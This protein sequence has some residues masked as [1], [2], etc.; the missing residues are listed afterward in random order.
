MFLRHS[1][2]R[3]RA[4]LGYTSDAMTRLTFSAQAGL[5]LLLCQLFVV[6]AFPANDPW[7]IEVVDSG[8]P[9]TIA[10]GETTVAR[11]T[12]GNRGTEEWRISEY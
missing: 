9:A 6:G 1:G 5:V 8:V 7:D 12:L 3:P 4:L 2:V 10:A 11:V